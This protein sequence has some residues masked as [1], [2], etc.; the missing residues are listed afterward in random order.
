VLAIIAGKDL[1][2]FIRDGRLFWA[3]GLIVVLMLTAVAVGWTHQREVQ[4]EHVSGQALDYDAW[5]N[6]GPR[7][8]HDAAT[9]G[10]HVFKPEP[11]L[12]IFDPGIEPF[13]GSTVWLQ[14]HRQSEVKFRPAQDATGLRRFGNLSAAWV[15]QT[16][17]SLLIIILGFNA[18]SA[19]RESG[20]LRQLLSLGV[21]TRALLLGKA[22]ALAASVAILLIPGFVFLAVMAI[23]GTSGAGGLDAVWRL[24][25]LGVGYGLYLGFYIFLVLAVSVL[26][27]SSRAALI[28]LLGLWIAGS[29]V[30]PRAASEL[31]DLLDPTPSRLDFDNKLSSELATASEEVWLKNF[32]VRTKWD[33]SVPLNKWG[34]ALEI[35]DHA[36][37]GVYDRN[38]GALWDTF[39]RHQGMHEWFGLVAPLLA[40]RGFSMGI[41]GTDFAQHRDFTTAAETQRRLIQDIVS[42]DLVRHADP[43]GNAHFTY[44]AG[45]ELWAT[46][47][48]FEYHIPPVSFAL[49]RHWQGLLTLAIAFC[50]S[51][52]LAGVAFSRRLMQ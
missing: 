38:F 2:E 15:L 16:L 9:Q 34:E 50:A 6:Q 39:E 11:P 46:V 30:A 12:A 51:V 41:A 27:R 47:P 26:A 3:G 49:A 10:M 5:L 13:V 17:A 28:V 44:K 1:R 24:S 25:W 37:Y 31:A 33:P 43:L 35:D 36:G 7:H 4:A 22:T 8:P 21:S 23:V 20:T 40:V 32:G 42:D 29:L 45:S 18:V 14:A 48:R 52:M 19:E